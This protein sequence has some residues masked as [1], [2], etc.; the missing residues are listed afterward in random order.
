M[1]EYYK[2]EEGFEGTTDMVAARACRKRVVD[3]NYKARV[4]AIINYYGTILGQKV[5][6]SE[7]RQMTLTKPSF[8][9]WP[10][11]INIVYFEIRLNLIL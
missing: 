5:T 1:Q 9:R 6:K 11:N 3:I 2:L 8:L 10:K 4:Q 7:A